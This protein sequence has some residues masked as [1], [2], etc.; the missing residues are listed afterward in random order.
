QGVLEV[1]GLSMVGMFAMGLPALALHLYSIALTKAL[2]SYSRSLL[3]ERCAARGRPDRADEVAH[4]DQ[5]TE[6]SA[7]A[8]AVVT[9]L[10]LA[11][12]VGVE[13]DRF[14][15]P[16]PVEWI[17]L[18]ILAIGL[19]GYVL[20]GAIGEVFAEAILD[21][22]WPATAPLRAVAWPLTFGLR[23]VERL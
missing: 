23:L 11:A 6:R 8:L 1:V 5:R 4:L 14:G 12:L 17:V 21:A 16:S 19:L 2:R 9:G 18:L 20:A 13:I 22:T 3:E 10:F 7:E 15:S